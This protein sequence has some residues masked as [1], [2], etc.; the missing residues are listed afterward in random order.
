M[1]QESPEPV[2]ITPDIPHEGESGADH[3][4][5][6]GVMPEAGGSSESDGS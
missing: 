4:P 5:Q 1:D 2:V 3:M 6:S